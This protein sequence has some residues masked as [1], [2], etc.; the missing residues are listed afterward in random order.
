M[1][2]LINITIK[3]SIFFLIVIIG[4]GLWSCGGDDSDKIS[5]TKLEAPTIIKVEP[6]S[7]IIGEEV[8]ITGTNFSAVLADNVVSFNGTEATITAVTS[9]TITTT[10]PD[11]A[12]TGAISVKVVNRIA[13]GPEFTVLFPTIVSYAPTSA[14]VG[15]AVV[16]TGTNFS[17]TPTDNVVS[18]NGTTA[19]VTASTSTSITTTVPVGAITGAITVSV[20]G[21]SVTGDVFTVE[22]PPP[23]K[24]TIVSYAPTSALV[25]VTVVITGTNFSTTPADNVVNF[26]GTTATVTASTPTSITTTVPVGAAT[27][28]I[29]VVVNGQSVT[30]DVFT[31]EIPP[32][33][34]IVSYA[35]ASALVGAAVVI[36]GTNFST[37][38]T[39]NVVSFNGTAATVTASTPTSITTTVPVGAATGAITV[40]VNGQ[41]VTGDVFTVEIP[42]SPTIVSYA[43]TSALVGAAV[44]ITGTNFSTTPADNVVSF[45]G[46]AATVTASTPTSITTTVPFGAATGAITVSVNGQSVT[47]DVFTVEPPLPT[48]PVITSFAPTRALVGAAVVITGTNFSTTPADNMVSFNGTT[49]I[50]TASTSTSITTTVPVG[51]ITGA[52]TVSVNG[53]SVTGA[54]FTVVVPAV[55]LVI[56]LTSNDDDAEEVVLVDPNAEPGSTENVL[57]FIDLGSSDLEFGE[58]SDDQGLMTTGLR[59]NS[60]AIPK[61]ATITSATIQFKCDKEGAD[62]VEMTIFGE[63]VANAQE[64]TETNGNITSRPLTTANAVWNIPTWEAAGDRLDAQKTVDLANIVQEIVNRTDWASGNSIAFILKN[65]GVSADVTVDDVGREAENYSGGTDDGA[66]LTIVFN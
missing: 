14:L 53:Q 25:G 23:P 24:P 28:A 33:P 50:V 58:I 15:A 55:T 22:T 12:T 32:P 52:I 10:V 6:A 51:A 17:T 21:Q 18:F 34:T 43:P 26:N 27:G 56:P 63:N 20:N 61:R 48:A 2:N 3:H 9:T 62:P 42:P 49:A 36:T 47:G 16:I 57:G 11:G 41:S 8:I 13:K 60:V 37:T 54:V 66:E 1:K 44:V 39:D 45:N 29:T 38:P 46:T 64:F 35:P 7:A 4:T 40:S 31:V 30:G 59:F 65:T 5:V 19:T